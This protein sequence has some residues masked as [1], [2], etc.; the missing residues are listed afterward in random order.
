MDSKIERYSIEQL[1][2]SQLYY[3]YPFFEPKQQIYSKAE[4][5]GFQDKVYCQKSA[6]NVNFLK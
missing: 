6:Y 2:C 5:W 3:I 1:E 4:K